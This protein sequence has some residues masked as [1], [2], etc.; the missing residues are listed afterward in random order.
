M[1]LLDLLVLPMIEGWGEEHWAALKAE[2]FDNKAVPPGERIADRARIPI[3][4]RQIRVGA[5]VVRE[6]ASQLYPNP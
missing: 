4:N 2:L 1:P 3:K 6:H 5:G